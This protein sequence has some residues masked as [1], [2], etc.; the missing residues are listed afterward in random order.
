MR[1]ESAWVVAA[2]SLRKGFPH[3]SDYQ[4]RSDRLQGHAKRHYTADEIERLANVGDV[5]IVL[6]HDAPAGVRFERHRRGKP[7]WSLVG[8]FRAR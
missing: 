7:E 3:L 5:D 1:R 2:P 8:E 6:T 4:R